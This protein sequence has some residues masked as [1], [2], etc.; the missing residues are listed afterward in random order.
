MKKRR[1]CVKIGLEALPKNVREKT[2]RLQ[3]K[4]NRRK[5]AEH[6]QRK[7]EEKGV[8]VEITNH[9]SS[10]VIQPEEGSYKTTSA[11]NKAVAK[12][13]LALP[14][15][16]QKKK[17][18]VAKL[19]KSFDPIDVQDMVAINTTQPKRT[20]AISPSDIDQVKA[21]YDRDDISRMSPN[22]KDCRNFVDPI[23]GTKEYKQLR[24]LMYK[25]AD[26]YAMFEKHVQNGEII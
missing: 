16:S 1:D 21:F 10:V 2:Q 19:L 5:V 15:T 18:A 22:V 4:Y 7:K 13:K 8:L 6:R 11:L 23:T 20:K 26:V 17:Q 25:L 14:S 9:V 12:L 3:R 24:F